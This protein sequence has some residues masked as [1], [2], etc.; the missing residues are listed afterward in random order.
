MTIT[1]LRV[2]AK[3]AQMTVKCQFRENLGNQF[4]EYE[5]SVNAS[6]AWNKKKKVAE[7]RTSLVSPEATT[8][9]LTEI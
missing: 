8:S 6:I 4:T 2:L 9:P 7:G 5:F 3:L 1:G